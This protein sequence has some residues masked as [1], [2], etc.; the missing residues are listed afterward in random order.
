MSS[1]L[2]QRKRLVRTFLEENDFL[3][4]NEGKRSWGQ[5]CA[6]PNFKRLVKLLL[7]RLSFARGCVPEEDGRH[8]GTRKANRFNRGP[9][10][11]LL[12]LGARC[13]LKYRG[14]TPEEYAQHKHRRWGGYDEVLQ[15]FQRWPQKSP[16]GWIRPFACSIILKEVQ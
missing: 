5:T 16:L 7:S 8:Q 3:H 4:V 15:V 1:C 11:A 14:K 12:M 6:S 10:Q 9:Q 13:D 2:D